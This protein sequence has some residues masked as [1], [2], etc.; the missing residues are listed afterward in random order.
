V[1]INR[2]VNTQELV[3]TKSEGGQSGDYLS[4]NARMELTEEIRDFHSEE[5]SITMILKTLLPRSLQ[6]YSALSFY[7]RSDL[8]T[9]GWLELSHEASD[10]YYGYELKVSSFWARV[11]VPFDGLL[12]EGGSL[13]EVG[14]YPEQMELRLFFDLPA[15]RVERALSRSAGVLEFELAVDDFLLED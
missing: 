13:E 3:L 14:E 8:L 4:V 10:A 7:I 9:E 15:Q 1:K 6:G 5:Q 12:G 11:R 2:G